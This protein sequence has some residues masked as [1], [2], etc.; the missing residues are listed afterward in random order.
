[1][2]KLA[3]VFIFFSIFFSACMTKNHENKNKKTLNFKQI[4]NALV[5]VNKQLLVAEDEQ[6]EAFIKR[7]NWKMEETGTGLRYNIYKHG[8]GRKA[9]KGNIAKI[10][11][12]VKLL[13][14][15][16]C[17]SSKNTGPKEFIIGKGNIE[18][19]LEQGIL[20]LK[21]GDKAKFILP[22]HLAFGLIGDQNKIPAKAALVYDIE[23]VELK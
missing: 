9:K 1:M 17:Y 20:L 23:L 22:S 12:S 13:N 7:Y 19:G 14:G 15:K 21:L 11:Y 4:S 6:I 10:N 8:N 5:K 3:I 18:S 2:K 16:L